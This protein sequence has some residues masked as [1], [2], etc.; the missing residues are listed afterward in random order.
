MRILIFILCALFAISVAAQ[1]KKKETVVKNP[2]VLME[3]IE[4]DS[5]QRTNVPQIDDIYNRGDSI[6]KHIQEISDSLVFYKVVKI[7]NSN[8][9]DTIA[10]VV[11]ENG[12]IR[13]KYAAFNQYTTA[14]IAGVK[15]T[16]DAACLASDTKNLT[17]TLLF[18]PIERKKIFS[19]V[20]ES[21]AEV[22]G[23]FKNASKQLGT[24]GKIV[25]NIFSA[26]KKQREE[27]RLFI[28]YGSVPD[29][30]GSESVSTD[31]LATNVISKTSQ[32]ILDE[33]AIAEEK[34]KIEK[35]KND[36]NEEM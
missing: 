5:P 2:K 29:D 32:Q 18:N 20:K 11:D 24:M 34:D 10:A 35:D 31:G 27:I 1:K 16:G 23:N 26:F 22:L 3:R 4:W 9:G 12:L 17:K 25:P 30:S 19:V 8:T 14:T 21:P 7:V 13:S 36:I 15:L 6:Y 28:K 33:I